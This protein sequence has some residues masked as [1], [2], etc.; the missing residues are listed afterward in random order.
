MKTLGSM[1]SQ[2]SQ[3]AM[4]NMRTITRQLSILKKFCTGC[5]K[6]LIINNYTLS[7]GVRFRT[8]EPNATFAGVRFKN[9]V[10]KTDTLTKNTDCRVILLITSPTM[11]KFSR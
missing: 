9:S 8:I 1:F 7:V 10:P 6:L 11:V 5:V 3:L 4:Y 2:F